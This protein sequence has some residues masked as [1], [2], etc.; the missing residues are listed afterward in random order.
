MTPFEIV[1]LTTAVYLGVGVAFLVMQPT[2]Q[3]RTALSLAEQVHRSEGR[4]VPRWHII[5]DMFSDFIL[6]WPIF[7]ILQGPN[8][9]GLPT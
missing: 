7:L 6:R 4:D 8:D 5:L 1:G 9:T 3:L 2:W